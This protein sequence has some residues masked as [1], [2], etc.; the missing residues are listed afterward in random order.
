MNRTFNLCC[1]RSR[2]VPTAA[3]CKAQKSPRP[4]TRGAQAITF[5]AFS[6]EGSRAPRSRHLSIEVSRGFGPPR[7]GRQRPLAVGPGA[8]HRRPGDAAG[9][10][11]HLRTELCS[12]FTLHHLAFAHRF[13][14]QCAAGR[15]RGAGVH[16]APARRRP[17]RAN[18]V[19]SCSEP[20]VYVGLL[21]PA[22][23]MGWCAQQVD[24][25]AGNPGV[26]SV[27]SRRLD[28]R[29]RRWPDCIFGIY[30]VST[31]VRAGGGSH[32]PPRPTF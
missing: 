28:R 14:C 16:A 13:V 15:S 4:L 3:G 7:T 6:R 1:S 23:M 17:L 11:P 10:V 5:G 8:L 32:P 9:A 29:G 31:A 24:S 18:I 26:A 27:G 12:N 20:G 22:R 30:S 25:V 21:G 2:C 19:M